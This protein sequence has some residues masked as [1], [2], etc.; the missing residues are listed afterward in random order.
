MPGRHRRVGTGL[1]S[2][3]NLPASPAHY[4]WRRCGVSIRPAAAARRGGPC[5]YI[6]KVADVPRV[7]FPADA[8]TKNMK[9][10]RA[11]S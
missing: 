1:S 5:V 2:P 10:G 7:T 9:W 6:P 4:N 8:A 11:L 3:H